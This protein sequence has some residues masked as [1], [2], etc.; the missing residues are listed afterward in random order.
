MAGS[1]RIAAHT[2]GSTWACQGP[3]T[4]AQGRSFPSAFGGLVQWDLESETFETLADVTAEVS[5]ANVLD[6]LETKSFHLND[7][8]CRPGWTSGAR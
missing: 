4:A 6:W 7:V 2:G 5:L 3:E 1:L 8:L